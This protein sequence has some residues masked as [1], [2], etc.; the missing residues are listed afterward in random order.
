MSKGPCYDCEIRHQ[1]CHSK[2]DEYLE[3]KGLLDKK[4]QIVRESRLEYM[5]HRDY[6]IDTAER[7]KR[8]RG[9]R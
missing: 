6:S 5:Q 8:K 4:K 7:L 2:C 9:K 3:Y 1:G